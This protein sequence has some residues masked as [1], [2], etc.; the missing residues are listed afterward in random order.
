VRRRRIP[1]RLKLVSGDALGQRDE[2][3]I[4]IEK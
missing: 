1:L 4:V 3:I 2:G